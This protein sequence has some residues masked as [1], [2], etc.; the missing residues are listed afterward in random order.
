MCGDVKLA[1]QGLNRILEGKESKVK[2]DF[3]AWRAELKEQKVKFPLGFKTF[4]ESISP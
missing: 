3:S 4:G 1:L 2:L